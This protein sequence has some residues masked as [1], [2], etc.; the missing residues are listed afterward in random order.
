M[1]LQRLLRVR[2]PTRQFLRSSVGPSRLRW[3]S[4]V[5]YPLQLASVTPQHAALYKESL[6]NPARFWGDLARSKL[7]WMEDFTQTMD[8]D[9]SGDRLKWFLGGKINVSVN[10][11]DRH[12]ETDPTKVALIWERDEPED[13]Q[14]ITYQELLDETCRLGNL[15]KRDGVRKGDRVAIYMP[16]SPVAVA[17]MLACARIGAVHNVVFAGFSA[18]S[19]RARIIDGGVSVVMTAD[20]GVRGGRGIPLKSV[21]DDAVEGVESVRRVFVATRTGSKVNM[22]PVRDV[23][24]EQAMSSE[25]RVCPPEALDSEDSLFMLYTSG[26]TGRPKGLVHTQ[27][28]YLLYAALTQ[29]Y[30]FDYHPERGDVFACV[31][32]IGWITGH[33]YVVYGPLCNGGTTVLFESVPTYPN[34]GRYWEMVERL[35]VTHFYTAPTAIRMLLKFG[36]SWVSKYDRSSLRTLGCVG[37]PLNDEA[38]LW[39]NNVVGEDRCT[40]VDTWW[41][42]E[43]GGIMISPRPSPDDSTPKPGLPMTPFFG[44]EPALVSPETGR[45]LEGPNVSGHLC[46]QR[47]WPGMARTIHGDHD[48]FIN[49]YYRPYPGL[50]FSGDGARRDAEGHYQITGRVDDV[51]NVKGHRIGTAELESCVDQNESIAETAVVGYPH[52]TFGE[53]IYAFMV[54]MEGVAVD[55]EELVADI[56]ASI[57]KKIG[58]FA[59]PQ[60]YLIVPGLPKTRSGK[61]MRR[62][63]KKISAD[64]PEELGDTSTLADPAVVQLILTKHSDKY[65]S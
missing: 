11:L 31:A 41:Q 18:E 64:Q 24:L 38:W 49:T 33:S 62:I 15:L 47:P 44:I 40:V 19:L 22:D 23:P 50:Y 63:L 27:A 10:L 55:E 53:A 56:Q 21:V 45:V 25:S 16:V 42:T 1:S 4:G 51:I 17:A 6:V 34:P 29:Q 39:Y 7:H 2:A 65:V 35:K 36:D 5:S 52:D 46:I 26:S 13:H 37:E 9:M 48:K 59:V 3:S 57:R 43:T 20:E 54:P 14:I 12:V 58:S 61:I 30:A 28:G 32:D 8:C 60:R